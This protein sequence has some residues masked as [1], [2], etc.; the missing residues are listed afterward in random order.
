[1]DEF[2]LINQYFRPLI[3]NLGEA[4]NFKD[5]VAI[6]ANGN[7]VVSKDVMVEN[8]HFCLRDGGYN[9]AQRL[10]RTN[11]SD[12]AAS[13]C[14]PLYYLLGF[15]KNQDVDENFLS[16]FNRALNEINQEFKIGLIGG[17][18]VKSP[19]CLFFSLTIFGQKNEEIL[20]RQNAEIEDL[21]FTSGNIGDAFLGRLISEEKIK[22][23]TKEEGNYL[24][25]RYFKPTPRIK[26]GLELNQKQL[27]NCA[28]DISDGLLADLK[29]ICFSSNLKATI[30]LEKILFSQSAENILQKQ[31]SLSKLDLISAGDDYE[32]IFTAKKEKQKPIENLAQK[33]QIPLTQI[34]YLEK[35]QKN[36]EPG[37]TLFSQGQTININKFGYEH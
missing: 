6:I 17:D 28:I 22:I 21:I 9:I 3:N 33:L 31:K 14:K 27:S 12:I 16:E 32:L 23:S 11:L 34:G 19:N 29:Q 1:M 37:V 13:G 18:T 26:L 10:L 2:S 8:I 36:E 35:I 7:L 24:K 4:Q 15:S 5:D 20:A 30:Y 25:N